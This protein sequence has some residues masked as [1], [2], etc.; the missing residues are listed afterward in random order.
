MSEQTYAGPPPRGVLKFFTR[1]NVFVYKLTGGKV[2][3]KLGGMPIVLIEMTGAK[4]GARRT[5]PLMYVPHE[6]GFLLV[7]SQGG[8]PRHPVWYY[9]L[10]AHPDVKVTF[11]GKTQPMT[12]RQLSSEEKAEVWPTCCEYYPPYQE[13]QDFT[14]RDIPVFLCE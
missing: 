3:N 13:Y 4:S 1:V 5:I 14:D 10:K 12:A 9:N 11:E 8:A 7:A 6:S 2:M